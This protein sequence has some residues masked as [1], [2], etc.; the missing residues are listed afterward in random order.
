M[1]IF[2][3]LHEQIKNILHKF[4]FVLFL[5]KTGKERSDPCCRYC[6]NLLIIVSASLCRPGP[7]LLECEMYGG[8]L[9][10]YACSHTQALGPCIIPSVYIYTDISMQLTYLH[11]HKR[12]QPGHPDYNN[13]HLLFSEMWRDKQTPSS[14]LL[15]HICTSLRVT[16]YLSVIGLATSCAGDTHQ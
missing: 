14:S 7:I 10:Q 9:D 1:D 6:Q 12:S 5:H 2:F 4:L 3:L 11:N 15:T 13:S 16:V 8:V